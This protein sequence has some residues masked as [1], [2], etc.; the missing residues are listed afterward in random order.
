MNTKVVGRRVVALIID[1][2]LISAVNLAIF[3]AFAKDPV[4]GVTS[5]DLNL[6][7]TIY[8]NFTIGDQTYSVYGGRAAAYFVITLAISIGY[9]VVLQG[10]KGVTLGKAMLGIRVVKD[11]GS[12]RPP[13]IGRAF[14]RWFLW[15]ADA[16][17]YFIPYLLGFIVAMVNKQNKRVGDMA[18]GT[19]VVDKNT[20][21][22]GG[23]GTAAGLG[24]QLSPTWVQGAQQPQQGWPQAPPQQ[25]PP[26]QYPP[27]P[28]YPPQQ[29]P[30]QQ[31][32]PPQWPPQ[33]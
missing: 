11:D 5:G 9:F 2:L 13:G 23:P 1:L 3:F 32:P 25:Y 10:L 33:Q 21:A 14:G 19:L 24:G 28:P 8:G 7:S 16:F 4:E 12:G 30:P 26:Q 18:A 22:A 6:D 31:Q 15:I 20:V 29:Q 17:P 27:Q